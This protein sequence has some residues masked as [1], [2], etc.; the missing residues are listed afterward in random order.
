[1]HI[2]ILNFNMNRLMDFLGGS[3]Y[4]KCF[5][6]FWAV[7]WCHSF[8]DWWTTTKSLLQ[9]GGYRI[10]FS[11]EMFSSG[12]AMVCQAYKMLWALQHRQMAGAGS[13][14]RSDVGR[15]QALPQWAFCPS[16][17]QMGEGTG[18]HFQMAWDH[19]WQIALSLET[20]AIAYIWC[21]GVD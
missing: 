5:T 12:Y 15:A 8:L 6:V 9:S 10:Y 17:A 2:V 1:M 16:E 7:I 4:R 18:V 20:H 19:P 21:H 14:W 11:F 13:R 3:F